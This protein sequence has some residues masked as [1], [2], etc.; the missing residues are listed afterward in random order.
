[1]SLP[2]CHGTSRVIYWVWGHPKTSCLVLGWVWTCLTA[3]CPH[4]WLVMAGFSL[5][6]GA[7]ISNLPASELNVVLSKRDAIAI[8]A[9]TIVQPMSITLHGQRNSFITAWAAFTIFAICCGLPITCARSLLPELM[10][11]SVTIL[12][13][14]ISPPQ[15][16]CGKSSVKNGGLHEG[17]NSQCLNSIVFLIPKL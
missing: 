6:M 17:I 12:W 8:P 10:Q 1:M 14:G 13:P 9:G 7:S 5:P 4:V 11:R 2:S 15:K 16:K 3:F